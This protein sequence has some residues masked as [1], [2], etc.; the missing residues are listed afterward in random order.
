MMKRKMKQEG[1]EQEGLKQAGMK[2]ERTEQRGIGYLIKPDCMARNAVALMLSVLLAGCANGYPQT[3]APDALSGGQSF[4]SQTASDVNADAQSTAD[5][6]AANQTADTQSVDNTSAGNQNADAQSMPA[7]SSAQTTQPDAGTA[8]GNNNTQPDA[9]TAQGS[10][11]QPDIGLEQAKD[12]A[13][14]HAGL[15][16]SDVTF[17]KEKLDYDDGRAEYDIE[18][19][20]AT[21]KYEYEVRAD[22]AAILEFSQEPVVQTGGNMQVQGGI[23]LEDA[24][25]AALDYVGLSEAQ[26]RFTQLEL[27]YDDGVAEYEIEFYVDKKEYSF[28][29]DAATGKILEVDID[30]D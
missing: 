19:V 16:A 8:Q 5:Q 22:D 2:Q 23:T 6:S 12:A 3:D 27:D 29:V 7:P 30:M 17:T 11:A 4:E 13:L 28:T 21:V 15:T 20:T 25:A 24:K 18:F 10:N 9:G 14:T 1:I 26:V